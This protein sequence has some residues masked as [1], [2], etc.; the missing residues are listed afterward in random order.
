MRNIA[1]AARPA[2]EAS[3]NIVSCSR[4]YTASITLERPRP[5]PFSRRASGRRPSP[6]RG[7]RRPGRP[8][9]GLRRFVRKSIRALIALNVDWGRLGR[10]GRVKLGHDDL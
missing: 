5:N 2:P 6:D 1:I 10:H 7:R 3:A 4:A 8:D 9:E